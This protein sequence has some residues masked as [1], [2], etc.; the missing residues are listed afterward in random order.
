MCVG[1]YVLTG[2]SEGVLNTESQEA[3]R[4]GMELQ[5]GSSRSMPGVLTSNA[6]TEVLR[7]PEL[8]A[9]VSSAPRGNATS[10]TSEAFA[11]RAELQAAMR[12]GK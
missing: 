10:R 8:L 3:L 12:V 6:I 4:M 7:S 1:T 9:R 11:G 5:N 2:G